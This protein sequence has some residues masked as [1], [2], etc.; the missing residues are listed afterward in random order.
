[1]E[2]VRAFRDGTEA[3][4]SIKAEP[5]NRFALEESLQI[6]LVLSLPTH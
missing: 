2:T 4:A 5:S 1:V 3:N 6:G